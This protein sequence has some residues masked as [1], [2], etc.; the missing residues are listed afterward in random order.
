[1]IYTSYYQNKLLR[2]R[3]DLLL[4]R[5]TWSLPRFGV[6]PTH[7]IPE[8]YPTVS[9]LAMPPE[10]YRPAYSARLAKLDPQEIRAG[11]EAMQAENPGKHI[12]LLCFCKPGQFC[13]R[14]LLAE[15]LTGLGLGVTEFPA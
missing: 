9:I 10:Q 14:H 5:V 4:V 2:N 12:V 6:K 3:P 15:Y 1:M 7:H 13:H 8:F 11:F